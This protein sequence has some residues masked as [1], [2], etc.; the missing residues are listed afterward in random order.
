MSA[1]QRPNPFTFVIATNH[2][3]I[4]QPIESGEIEGAVTHSHAEIPEIRGLL[5]AQPGAAEILDR[6]S[7]RS[8]QRVGASSGK[9]AATR[10]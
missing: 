1:D 6:R 4:G 5:T 8:R 9:A 7:P 2:V 3:V 10:E